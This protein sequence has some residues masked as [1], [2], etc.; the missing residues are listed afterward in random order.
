MVF[1]S[2]TNKTSN[3][4]PTEK[5]YGYPYVSTVPN[6]WAVSPLNV[7]CNTTVSGRYLTVLVERIPGQ[8]PST[9]S[10]TAF[11]TL[12]EVEIEAKGST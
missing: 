4:T 9:W 7:S 10:P 1:A 6:N 12:C 3:W 8:F 11:L 2:N 5:C